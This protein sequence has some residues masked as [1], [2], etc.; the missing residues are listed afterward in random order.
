MLNSKE[1]SIAC[2]KSPSASHQ[3][4]KLLSEMGLIQRIERKGFVRDGHIVRKVISELTPKGKLVVGL[5]LDTRV[6]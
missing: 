1:I 3:A 4:R 5:I 6:F 2:G